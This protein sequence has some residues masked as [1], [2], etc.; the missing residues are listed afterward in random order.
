MFV[1]MI[2]MVNPFLKIS[3]LPFTWDLSPAWHP[4]RIEPCPP[5]VMTDVASATVNHLGYIR[6]YLLPQDQPQPETQ[7]GYLAT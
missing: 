4:V 2:K 1:L 7:K 5:I 6:S 3:L